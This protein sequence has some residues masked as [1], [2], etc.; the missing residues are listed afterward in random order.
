M[1]RRAVLALVV[2]GLATP[3]I[4]VAQVPI[5]PPQT[6]ATAPAR[7]GD[8]SCLIRMMHLSSLASKA[9]ED[10]TKDE[11][12]RSSSRKVESETRRAVAYFM[13]RIG[14][15]GFAV[16]RSEEGLAE[17]KTMGAIPR[18]QLASEVKQCLEI[19]RETNARMVSSLKSKPSTK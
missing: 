3:T 19:V 12:Y 5:Q 13:G 14:P 7:L 4:A 2:A 11:A 18:E 17:F 10:T 1:P 6:T 9:A 8:L 16:N 15:D